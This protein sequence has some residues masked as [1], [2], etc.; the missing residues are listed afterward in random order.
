MDF[1]Q[2]FGDFL[3]KKILKEGSFGCREPSLPDVAE[4]FIS[5][6]PHAQLLVCPLHLLSRELGQGSLQLL[7]GTETALRGGTTTH[8]L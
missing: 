8:P 7:V 5:W 6:R 4:L 3:S 2:G 1:N